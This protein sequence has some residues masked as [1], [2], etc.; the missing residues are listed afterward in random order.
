MAAK[1][2]LSPVYVSICSGRGT[3]MAE[4]VNSVPLFQVARKSVDFPR[5]TSDVPDPMFE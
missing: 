5:A 2:D 3:Y 4:T 1:F